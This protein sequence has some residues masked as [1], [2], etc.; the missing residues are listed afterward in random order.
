[1]EPETLWCRAI[2]TKVVVA[3]STEYQGTLVKCQ[4]LQGRKTK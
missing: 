1:M 3:V 4:N 2:T